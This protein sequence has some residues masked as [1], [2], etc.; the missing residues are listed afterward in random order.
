MRLPLNTTKVGS[1]A[2]GSPFA[3]PQPF[4]T[5]PTPSLP[6]Q[7]DPSLTYQPLDVAGRTCR[8]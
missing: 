7:P 2:P 8:A 5:C 1:A 6:E 3:P 4:V